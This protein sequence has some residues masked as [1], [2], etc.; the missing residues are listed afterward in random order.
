MKTLIAEDDSASRHILAVTLKKLGHEVIAASTGRE[1]WATFQTESVHLVISDWMMPE[2]DGLE[3]CRRIRKEHR[4]KYTYFILLTALGGK[5]SYMEGMEAGADD[6]ITKP[7]APE[8]VLT[9]VDRL[10]SRVR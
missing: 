7:F 1:A 10:L 4:L 9:R 2:M 6:F 8:E 3:L 5:S